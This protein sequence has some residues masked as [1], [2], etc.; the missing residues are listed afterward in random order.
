MYKNS[1]VQA[2]QRL[3]QNRQGHY[4]DTVMEDL[5]GRVDDLLEHQT[6]QVL[7]VATYLTN[8]HPEYAGQAT[9]H[10]PFGSVTRADFEKAVAR[11]VGYRDWSGV[12]QETKPVDPDFERAVDLLLAGDK[13]ALAALLTQKPDLI[14]QSSA[15]GHRAGLVHYVGANGV[16][17][18][19]QQ[20]PANLPE[21]LQ[22]L[23][24]YGADPQQGHN[25][26]QGNGDVRDLIK[27]SAHPKDAGLSS[28]LLQVL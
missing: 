15:Y 16:E 7:A 3:H 13:E 27:T 1:S 5:T 2:V 23:L 25:I 12:E 26:Y 4:A 22:L 28:E 21:I 11:T 17:L 19:R 24:D 8:G 20:V 18:W 14:K 6:D 9:H 10:I